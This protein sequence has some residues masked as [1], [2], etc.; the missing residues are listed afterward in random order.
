MR[1]YKFANVTMDMMDEFINDIVD[2]VRV[3]PDYQRGYNGDQWEW[4]WEMAG[5]N[6]KTERFADDIFDAAPRWAAG[7]METYYGELPGG[8]PEGVVCILMKR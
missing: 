1:R 7:Q 5:P 4:L 2:Y 8:S 3:E 6:S